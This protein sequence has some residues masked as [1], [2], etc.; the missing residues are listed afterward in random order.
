MAKKL[1]RTTNSFIQE[2]KSLKDDII[3]LKTHNSQENDKLKSI[4]NPEIKRLIQELNQHQK[5]QIL[6]N[7][8]LEGQMVVSS[9]N[10]D[11]MQKHI[12]RAVMSLSLIHI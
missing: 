6:I 12:N 3:D 4:F 5:E 9:E 1:K 11:E 8:G 2:K 10:F 7:K